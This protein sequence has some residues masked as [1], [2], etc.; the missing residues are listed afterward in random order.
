MLGLATECAAGARERVHTVCTQGALG[1]SGSGS[2]RGIEV[3]VGGWSGRGSVLHEGPTRADAR[4]MKGRGQ[5]D[6]DGV[7][8]AT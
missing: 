6:C 8:T 1:G 4:I 7:D 3:V 5:G 2:K